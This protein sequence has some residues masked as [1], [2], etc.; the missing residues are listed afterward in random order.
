[1]LPPLCDL[2]GMPPTA[3]RP[4]QE[5]RYPD[6]RLLQASTALAAAGG[7]CHFSP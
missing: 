1:M 4:M 3:D 7:G 5:G 6:W 2:C